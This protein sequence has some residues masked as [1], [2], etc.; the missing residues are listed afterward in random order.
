MIVSSKRESEL[1]VDLPVVGRTSSSEWSEACQCPVLSEKRRR[2]IAIRRAVVD[3]I[4]KVMPTRS[5]SGCI[6]CRLTHRIY[7]EEG[8]STRSAAEAVTGTAAKTSH[9][10]WRTGFD[11]RFPTLPNDHVRARRRLTVKFSRPRAELRP[12]IRSEVVGF[13]TA[14]PASV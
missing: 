7:R 5:T 8:P 4:E 3:A 10:P 1:Q 6:S 11:S 2:K 14:E 13:E 9:S 12:M